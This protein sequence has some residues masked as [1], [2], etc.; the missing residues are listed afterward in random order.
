MQSEEEDPGMRLHRPG[1]CVK[2]NAGGIMS[3][4][5]KECN[6]LKVDEGSIYD[7]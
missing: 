1:R 7:L 4:T 3:G 2:G 6:K 5:T